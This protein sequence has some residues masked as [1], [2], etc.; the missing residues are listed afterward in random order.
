MTATPHTTATPQTTA[1]T[2]YTVRR[3]TVPVPG[4]REFQRAY[5][6]AVP[7][8]PYDEVNAL[9]RKGAPWSD[10]VKLM[11]ASAPNGFLI[12][13]RNDVH[14]VMQAAGDP[15]DSIAYLMGNHVTA[16]RMFRYDPRVM[17]YAPLHTVI[18]EDSD[19]NAWFTVD[20]PSTQFSSFGIPAV[21]EVGVELDR[22]LA[23]L[24]DVLGVEVPRSLATT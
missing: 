18:W 3:L 1:E 17:L 16:E 24:L 22:E 6:Q 23:K 2:T 8:A 11:D 21:A 13:F 15:A 14:P 9:V 7:N 5:E 20:Q 4:V 10:M 12:Y 19:A